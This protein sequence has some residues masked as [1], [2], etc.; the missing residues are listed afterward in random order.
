MNNDT[1][2]LL[3]TCCLKIASRFDEDYL[4]SIKEI[5]D[6]YQESTDIEIQQRACEYD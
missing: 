4:P 1:I 5:I 2:L 3:L 6:S